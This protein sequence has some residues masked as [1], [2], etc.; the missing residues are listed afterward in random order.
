MTTTGPE[1]TGWELM[2]SIESLKKSVDGWAASMVTQATLAIYEAAQKERDARQDARLAAL[3]AENADNRKTKA[4]Q[5][6]AIGL[7]GLGFVSSVITAII[8]FNLNRGVA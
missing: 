5:W 4:Q 3:E 8:V 1:P 6:F 7:A 2:R